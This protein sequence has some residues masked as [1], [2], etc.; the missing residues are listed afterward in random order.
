MDLKI[1]EELIKMMEGSKLSSLEIEV[2]NMKI[3]MG[4]DYNTSSIEKDIVVPSLN[5]ADVKASREYSALEELEKIDI[6]DDLENT[7]VIKSPM[8]GTFYSSSSPDGEPFIKSGDLIHKGDTVCIIEAMKLMNE[9]DSE[10]D[11]TVIEVLVK[12]GEM[13]EY[14]TELFRVR[15]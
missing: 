14:G 6:Q 5:I 12:D 11:G 4:K 15:K 2:N 7:F 1:I 9:I 13:V 8:V 10:A 3:K